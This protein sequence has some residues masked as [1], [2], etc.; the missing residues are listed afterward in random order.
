M[1][2]VSQAELAMITKS[3]DDFFLVT[4][5]ILVFLMQL[6]FGFLEGG[7]VR[8][9]NVTNILLKNMLDS[10]VAAW[11][12]WSVGWAFAYGDKSNAF[13]GYSNF[14][15]IDLDNDVSALWFF[16]FTFTATAAT[17]V[18]GAMAERTRFLAY[19]LYSTLLTAFVYPVITHWAWGGGWLATECPWDGCYFVDFAGSAVLHCCGGAAA[20]IGAIAVGKRRGL[21][22]D[23]TDKNERIPGKYGTLLLR[24][25]TLFK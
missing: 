11:C 1:S 19:M 5:G 7:A 16:Q 24:H 20:L 4:M 10:A 25:Q 2:S 6:G 9:K 3:L 13:I 15:L 22:N 23:E 18:S 12:Y 14:F 8:T 17:I 21:Y